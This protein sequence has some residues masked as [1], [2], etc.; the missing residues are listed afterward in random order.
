MRKILSLLITLIVAYSC[1]IDDICTEPTTPQLILRFYDATSTTTLKATDSLYVWAE[2]KDSLFI[3]QATDSIALPL[4]IN[5]QT[6]VYNLAKGTQLL[7]QITV[8]YTTE[9]E[10][11]SRSCGYRVVFNDVNL[12]LNSPVNSWIS[13]VTPTSLTTINN[14]TAAHVQVFH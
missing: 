7:N 6:T 11:V 4:D 8:S 10:F 12:N 1:T 3:N 9:D 2:G 14:Q 5:A 13:S